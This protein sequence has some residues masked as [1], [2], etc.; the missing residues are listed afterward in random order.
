M[1]DVQVGDQLIGGDGRPCLVTGKSEPHERDCYRITFDDKTSVV[2]DN[3]HLW[4][5]EMGYQKP[6]DQKVMATED[7]AQNLTNPVTG[8]RHLRIP[9][10]EPLDL[11]EADLPIDPY[12]LGAWLGDGAAGGG[13]ICKPL[14][15]LFAEIARRGYK[16]GDDTSGPDR[17]EAR[18]I[19]GLRT[20]LRKAG[21]LNNKHVPAA[22]LRASRQQRLDLLRGIMDTDGHWNPKRQRCVVNV[23]DERFANEVRELALSL[24]YGARTFATTAT[25][26]GRT[27]DAWQTWFTP[28]DEVFIARRPDSFRVDAPA[29]AKRRIIH[30]VER[31]PTVTTQCVMVDSFD[32]TYLCG[33]Q[34]VVTHNTSRKMP[35][36]N[37]LRQD[38][39]FSAYT[40]AT[41]QAEFWTGVDNGAHYFEQAKGLE[42][43]AEWVQLTGPQRRHAGERTDQDFGRLAYA[44]DAMASSVAMGIFVPTI[45]GESCTF[46]D[47]RKHCGLKD[48][49]TEDHYRPPNYGN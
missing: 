8:S 7:L 35:T 40:Y 12:V 22:Y 25:G 16:V 11:P 34:M 32:Q 42:R 14:P 39:Q 37:Y 19:F 29:K 10:V 15:A 2:C 9:N 46:C 6:Y 20:Q 30:S 5:V 31:I 24:G 36:Y 43:E 41:T 28:N 33:E 4:Q 45:S 18:T 26:F 23:T 13:R 17:A 38:L 27:V 21:L 44:C 48:L 3:E 49:E 47:F 1:R